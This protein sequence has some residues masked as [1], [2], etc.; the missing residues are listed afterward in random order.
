VRVRVLFPAPRLR[1]FRLPQPRVRPVQLVF[2][3]LQPRVR[4]V[5]LV[6]RVL[7][8]RVRPVQLVF[9]VRLVRRKGCSSVDFTFNLNSCVLDALSMFAAHQVVGLHIALD[10]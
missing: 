9:R 8:P 2:R 5:Q 10:V 6:F 7:Q 3:V 1:R 4:P